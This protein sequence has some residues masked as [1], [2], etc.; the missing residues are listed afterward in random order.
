MAVIVAIV[1]FLIWFCLS[2]YFHS[3]VLYN[4]YWPFSNGLPP[5]P[6]TFVG[7]ANEEQEILQL[8]MMEK[9]NKIINIIGPPGFGKSTLA[10]C[11]GNTLISRGIVLHYVDMSQ[12][13]HQPVQQIIAEKILFQESAHS[14][15]TN[16]TF[17]HLL[18]WAARNVWKNLVIFDNCDEVLNYQKDQ[19]N[20]AVEMFVKQS[21]NFKVLIT[22]RE[23][24]LYLEQSR[25]VKVDSLTVNES[26]ELLE[27]KSPDLLTT[28]EKIAIAN[29]TGSVPLALQIVGSLLNRRLNPPSPSVIIEELQF[30]PIPTLS[31]AALH[32]KMRVNASISVSYNYLDTKLRKIARYIANFPGSFTKLSAIN[33]LRLVASNAMEVTEDYVGSGLDNL[34][35][36]S[37]L[38]YNPHTRRYH[39]HRLLREF[40]REVQLDNH[41]AEGGRFI[42]AFQI[43]MSL[44]LND[45]TNRFIRTPKMAL[46][47]LDDER[48]NVQFLL[49][50]TNR[51][52]NCTHKA[53]SA[54]ISSINTA[55]KSN[56]LTC[57]FSAEELIEI[58][59]SVMF[60]TR[61]KMLGERKESDI[62]WN[63]A[64]H[65][66]FVIHHF[67]SLIYLNGSKYATHWILKQVRN[68]ENAGE[69][70]VNPDL[71]RQKATAYTHFYINLLHY[72]KFIDDELVRL[73]N[74]RVLRKTIQLQP[75][76]AIV[77]FDCEGEDA[78]RQCPYKNIATA[79]FHIKEFQ[80][81]VQFFEKALKVEV[82]I[83]G[84]VA[85]STYLVQSYEYT[86][87]AEK[88]KDAFERTVLHIYEKV[89]QSPL[90]LAIHHHRSYVRILRKYGEIQK[91]LEL[92]KKELSELLE[93][94]A[95]GGI[96]DAL[97]AYDLAFQMYNH[98]NDTDAIT[99]A[100]L[101]LRI[102]EQTKFL[103]RVQ[104]E[105]KVLIG[106]AQN[107]IGNTTESVIR[108]K[109][110]ADW[111][112]QH[113][114]ISTYEVEYSECCW[115]LM[116]HTKYMN[117]CYFKKAGSFVSFIISAGITGGY[118]L[119]VSPLDLNVNEE[120][121]EQQVN[122]FEQL[123]RLSQIKDILFH[124]D[125][126]TEDYALSTAFHYVN[127]ESTDGDPK[128]RS[129]VSSFLNF[130][131]NF[132]L[133]FHYIRALINVLLVT[134]KLTAFAATLFCVYSCLNCC[135]CG[136]CFC[137][138]RRLSAFITILV[139]CFSILYT[140][141]AITYFD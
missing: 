21:N 113:D 73:Y 108:F 65:I 7:R 57:R 80:K 41:R 104:L 33:V 112:M 55:I 8:S 53:Y 10:I 50:I 91:A 47:E 75:D 86:G 37:L 136:C 97:T 109:E 19:F 48:H 141:L 76:P 27:I 49:K 90:T 119:L 101:A 13:T 79:Y 11:V 43:Q 133:Q 5:C 132:A 54:A 126:Q 34:V 89:L 1:A 62:L 22:S 70:I 87:D 71:Q 17:N 24:S 4:L 20:E 139:Y 82:T 15:M 118:Y 138:C 38:E 25:A 9:T 98:N 67:N 129:L 135:G 64:I 18:S 32:K 2:G 105:L 85:I 60:I 81:S 115:Y 95:K 122:P 121:L 123:T 131:I 140:Y 127:S 111:I 66:D 114:A 77:E 26:C 72:D 107:R 58:L 30:H 14:E 28:E 74:S 130:V 68:I 99:M 94:G 35:T 134:L 44:M 6:S 39:F 12:V 59:R 23:E 3:L 45:L 31:P 92:E 100:T 69:R 120:Q 106:K 124:K 61:N 42:L 88:A 84:L 46:L 96:D 137:C 83:S 125:S 93:T 51:P 103:T 116:F 16:V 128:P 63:Y 102:M 52:Y 117:E 110:V 36:S 40:F 56:F 78:Y 29:L